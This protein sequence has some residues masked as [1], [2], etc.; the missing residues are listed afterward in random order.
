MMKLRHWQ[1]DCIR[2]ALDH[3]SVD[4]HFFCQ[5]TPGAGKT[6]MVAELGLKLFEQDKID[7]VICF[8]PSCQIVEGI[9]KT[10]ESVLKKPFDGKIGAAGVAMTYQSI[11]HKDESFWRLFSSLRVFAVFDEIHHCSGGDTFQ[12]ANIWGQKI[13]QRIQDAAI[14]TM[15][16]SGTPWRSDDH[17][18][19]LARYSTPEGRLIVDYQYS[20]TQAI[21]D[22]VC[23]SPHITFVDN[24][25]I[26]FEQPD[27][28]Q[29]SY[30]SFASLLK[31]T[32]A[33]FESLVTHDDVIIHLLDLSRHRL[34]TIR[35]SVSDAGCLIVASNIDHAHQ[36]AG[37]LKS[38]MNEESI[39]VTTHRSDAAKI[40][41]QF[42]HSDAKWIVAVGMISEGTDIPRLQVCCYLSRIRTEMY[43]RQVL[44]RVLR[45]RS[46]ADPK[47]WMFMISESVLTACAK[48]LMESL[49]DHLAVSVH[50][51]YINRK[52]ILLQESNE[53]NKNI[54]NQCTES[55]E[56]TSSTANITKEFLMEK[57]RITGSIVLSGNFR[58]QLLA[59]F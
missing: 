42:R 16:M 5:A 43:F 3:F 25:E 33:N 13:I 23:R 8:A 48:R 19:A 24:T 53:C 49:P 59:F 44:G 28:K 4:Q 27:K 39:V 34:N 18:I 47:A 50:V 20:L 12:P 1:S 6:R 36:I 55:N 14:I 35:Q 38:R 31:K 22:G 10:F 52:G 17:S 40:I 41:D 51:N 21:E 57:K 9:Q 45:R 58:E 26:I 56:T 37:L 32:D 7:I 54:K 46:D 2:K 30:M 29:E 15:G 11:E